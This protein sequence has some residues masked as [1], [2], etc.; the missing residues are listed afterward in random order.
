MGDVLAEAGRA[1]ARLQ[2]RGQP[3]AGSGDWESIEVRSPDTAAL[4]VDWL[5][6]LIYR[7]E[8]AGWVAVD[9]EIRQASDTQVTA[10][11]RGVTLAEPPSLVKA[12]TFHGARVVPVAGG[13]EAN[14]VLD[15]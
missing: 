10:R 11:A 3:T 13:L 2:L 1:L 5:N 14:I 8:T 12:A 6:E 9:F 15:V 7:A 4:L